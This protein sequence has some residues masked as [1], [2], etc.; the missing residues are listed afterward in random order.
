LQS[1]KLGSS[2]ISVSAL[3]LGCNTFGVSVDEQ[4]ARAI[5]DAA[6]EVGVTFFDTA[7]VYGDG[8]SER[9]LGDALRGRREQ[10]VVATKFG[11]TPRGCTRGASAPGGRDQVLKAVDASLSRLDFD[12]VDV[13]YYHMP[14]KVT[15]L[16]ETLAAMSEVVQAGKARATAVS[17][18][19]AE[20]VRLAGQL[21]V[22]AVQNQ[23]SL[24]ERNA[25]AEVLPLCRALRMGFVPYMPLANGL[26]TGKYSRGQPPPVGSRLEYFGSLGVGQELLGEDRFDQIDQLARFSTENG[27]S[28]H[29][30]AIAALAS[31]P[32]IASVLV[33]ARSPTQVRANA[34]ASDWRL[35][36]GMRAAV[37]RPQ[38][39]GMD[40]GFR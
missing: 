38:S 7:P 21:G 29:E 28:L 4:R 37:P 36:A 30:L 24:L 2:A 25:D 40:L 10:A 8:A 39:L 34:A 1:R 33:G 27:H 13:L 15:P 16:E 32:G 35:D 5:V 31:E 3:G 14:D 19:N 12:H 11:A 17:N 22:S 26:L 23:Y 6:L 9:M 18:V 20:Q